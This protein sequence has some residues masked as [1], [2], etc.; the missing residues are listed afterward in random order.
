MPIK[1][2]EAMISAMEYLEWLC[3]KTGCKDCIFD[4]FGC[5]ALT[6]YDLY[7]LRKK[8]KELDEI[9]A[10]KKASGESE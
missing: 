6:K 7:L 3:E 8:G 1:N 9:N 5:P 4:D 2:Y 10:E